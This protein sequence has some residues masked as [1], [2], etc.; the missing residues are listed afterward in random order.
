MMRS[1]E[2]SDVIKEKGIYVGT[3]NGNSMFPML[4]NKKDTVIIRPLTGEVKKYDV[5]LY[6]KGNLYVL[7][8]IVRVVPGGYVIC[9]DNCVNLER[10]VTEEQIIGK[11]E[12]FYRGERQVSIQGFGYK[13]YCRIW[14][15]LYPLRWLIVG[16][17]KNK[18]RR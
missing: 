17:I 2:L 1:V 15:A 10:D 18:K 4:R 12:G 9:G 7:H 14:V 11:L 8:R 16:K 13:L 5:P 3:V 6:K